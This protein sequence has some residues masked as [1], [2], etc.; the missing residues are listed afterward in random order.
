[1]GREN[2]YLIT[3]IILESVLFIDDAGDSDYRWVKSIESVSLICS[4]EI[5]DYSGKVNGLIEEGKIII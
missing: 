4:C 3:L 1:M 5:K 2:N